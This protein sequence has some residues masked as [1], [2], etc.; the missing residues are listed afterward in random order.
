[1]SSIVVCFFL[2]LW[3]LSRALEFIDVTQKVGLDRLAPANYEIGSISDQNADKWND[4]ILV[5]E[6]TG[7]Q[8][9]RSRDGHA[10]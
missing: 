1:M 2:L 9:E 10:T 8:G 6:G 5:G 4:L 7:Q 3:N